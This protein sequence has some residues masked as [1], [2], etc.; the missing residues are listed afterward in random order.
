MTT[1]PNTASGP[2]SNSRDSHFDIPARLLNH[3]R[4]FTDFDLRV[5]LTLL[6]MLRPR[7]VGVVLVDRLAVT[8]SASTATVNRAL[9][10]LTAFG[11]IH[12][13]ASRDGDGL[14]HIELLG[15][16]LACKRDE[17]QAISRAKEIAHQLEDESNLPI[18]EL[19]SRAVPEDILQT[20][21]DKTMA[22]PPS[23]IRK[24]RAALFIHL[25]RKYAKPV[26]A[27]RGN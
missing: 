19:I 6:R 26:N 18:Y 23:D 22:V 4:V 8:L 27:D 20:T 21:L 16:E 24:S 5:Y 9:F 11:I 17:S 15:E 7:T 3:L 2:A 14:K 13:K 25:I 10:R 1:E 12:V